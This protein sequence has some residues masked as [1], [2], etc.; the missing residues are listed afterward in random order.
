[1]IFPYYVS[2]AGP[3]HLE[4]GK[5]CQD[6]YAIK[7]DKAPFHIAAVADGLG[8]ELFS[9]IGAS[10]AVHTAVDYCAE[11]LEAEMGFDRIKKVMNNALAYAYQAVLTKADEDQQD[12]E[13]YDSTLCLCIYDGEQL[14]YAQSG[15]SGLVVL[16]ENGEYRR[17]T[18]QQRDE[19]GRV[20]PLYWGPEK[21]EFGHVKEPVSAALLMTDGVFDKL[22]PPLLRDKD[23]DMNIPIARKLMDHFDCSEDA[24]ADLQ[25]NIHK[26][27]EHF[28]H[29]DDDKTVV[30]LINTDR[31]PAEMPQEYYTV[32]DWKGL[33]EEVKRKLYPKDDFTPKEAP[34]A[35]DNPPALAQEKEAAP[36]SPDKD[37]CEQPCPAPVKEKSPSVAEVPSTVDDKTQDVPETDQDD[38]KATRKCRSKRIPFFKTTWFNAVSLAIVLVFSLLAYFI[39]GWME[40]N[41][42]LTATG[43]FIACFLAHASVLLPVPSLLIVMKYSMVINPF[44][45]VLCAAA[46]AALGE[47][48]GFLAG[49]CGG[50]LLPSGLC[51]WLRKHFSASR[52]AT[53]LAFSALPLPVFDVVG[54]LA[55]ISNMKLPM[56]L[57][58]CF[59]GKLLKFLSYVWIA[60][61]LPLLI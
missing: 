41:L 45:A 40:K 56:F 19:A 44:L 29:L 3:H 60:H 50:R 8:S 22:C 59:C 39:S 36:A 43:I 27:L 16:L 49:N 11:H 6:A 28:P 18:T 52:N 9:D 14:Y 17:I 35:Q 7:Q 31:V 57:G 46:G 34:A 42:A 4:E 23:I 26:Y 15:D 54:I 38:A 20:F 61:A 37:E 13:Q 48:T 55:G 5:P 10:V 2:I 30:A 33:D 25:S 51:D 21:W 12:P 58:L 1:M 47:M 32:P 24:V 53:V